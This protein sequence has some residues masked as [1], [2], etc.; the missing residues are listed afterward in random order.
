MDKLRGKWA[1]VT[2]SSRGIGQQIALGL[3]QLGCNIIV[4]GRKIDSTKQTLEKLLGYDIQ[5]HAVAG[6]FESP[7]GISLVINGVR[8]HPG[9]I[10]IL[11]NNAAITGQSRAITHS[12]LETWQSV[13]QVN[14][15][16]TVMLSNAFVPSMIE[17]GFGRIVNLTSGIQDVPNL[18]AYSASK[19]AV[20]KYTKDFSVHLKGT[21]VQLS[22]VDPGWVKTEMG[23]E[24]ALFDVESVLPG[25]LMPML[26]DDPHDGSIRFYDAQHYKHLKL[27]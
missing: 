13:F 19:A 22:T 15:F 10:D 3:A 25:I 4:Q 6:D 27:P 20:D 5:T 18:A 12:P 21:G 23:G 7:H 24:N 11:Y 8:A 14:L 17:R 1:L 26:D 16:A 2:G 9:Q